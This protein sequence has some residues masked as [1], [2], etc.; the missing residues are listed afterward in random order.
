MYVDIK[1]QIINLNNVL[2][3]SIIK[4]ELDWN[5]FEWLLVVYWKELN[6]FID[7]KKSEAEL[8]IKWIVSKWIVLNK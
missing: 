7:M 3:F 2:Y 6:L 8:Y 1:W 5:H 4:K